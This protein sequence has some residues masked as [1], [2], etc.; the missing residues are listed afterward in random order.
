MGSVGK[1]QCIKTFGLC[2]LN[3]MKSILLASKM[4]IITV[5]TAGFHELSSPKD[6]LHSTHHLMTLGPSVS[7]YI[8]GDSPPPYVGTVWCYTILHVSDCHHSPYI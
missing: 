6:L 1:E 8:G 3:D 2:R 4:G 7:D 5:T